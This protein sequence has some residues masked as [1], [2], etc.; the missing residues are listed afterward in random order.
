M[1]W[2]V[3]CVSFTNGLLDAMNERMMAD[4]GALDVVYP[5][6]QTFSVDQQS[7]S[8]SVRGGV[9]TMSLNRVY[10]LQRCA[11]GN[12]PQNQALSYNE[13][14]PPVAVQEQQ[15]GFKFNNAFTN[16]GVLGVSEYQFKINNAP[17]PMYRETP[18]G[19]Y[20]SICTSN[21]RTYKHNEGSQIG[22]AAVWKGNMW[23]PCVSLNHPADQRFI[24]GL[25]L[26]S[27]NSQVNW[28]VYKDSISTEAGGLSG[29]SRQVM[30][31]TE[32][33]SLLKIGGGRSLAVIA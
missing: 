25:D 2:T 21:A 13:Q 23:S 14:Q 31:M 11:T 24:S 15:I 28:D 8:S 33:S 30:L 5:Q 6:Y 10:G 16:F 4:D 22:S 1:F 29:L 20:N 3:D 19:G 27:I 12:A 9:S 18:L 26:R 7:A 32:Q 17:Y